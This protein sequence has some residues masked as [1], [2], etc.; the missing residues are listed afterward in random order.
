MIFSENVAAT[1]K[2]DYIEENQS[3][4]KQTLRSFDIS[5]FMINAQVASISEIKRIKYPYKKK[6][7]IINWRKNSKLMVHKL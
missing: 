5:D 7:T 6:F 4:K 2:T 3:L 1:S